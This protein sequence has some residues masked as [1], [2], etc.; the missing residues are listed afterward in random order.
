[1][2]KHLLLKAC[3]VCVAVAAEAAQDPR[4]LNDHNFPVLQGAQNVAPVQ[5][6]WN[7]PAALANVMQ[8]PDYSTEEI[9]LAENYKIGLSEEILAIRV[10]H[11]VYD[12]EG[13]PTLLQFNWV[14][15]SHTQVELSVRDVDDLFYVLHGQNPYSITINFEDRD[16]K[17]VPTSVEDWVEGVP[18]LLLRTY[19]QLGQVNFQ[20]D[21][22]LDLGG[23]SLSV[24]EFNFPILQDGQLKPSLALAL[25]GNPAPDLNHLQAA[26][27]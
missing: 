21:I 13:Y 24:G 12:S 25:N 19:N 11:E 26:Q 20:Q 1:M 17:I 15:K 8:A 10:C 18:A 5:H 7:D 9:E 14:R 4:E 22:A 2:K 6:G 23:L 3:V 16:G 27:A